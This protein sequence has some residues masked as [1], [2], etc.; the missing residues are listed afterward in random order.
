VETVND[1]PPADAETGVSESVP[2]AAVGVS[3]N[4]IKDLNLMKVQTDKKINTVTF[5]HKT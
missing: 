2:A 1:C 4:K 3:Y 5:Y